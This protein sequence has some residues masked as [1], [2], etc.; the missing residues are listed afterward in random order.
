[1]CRSS[2]K[3]NIALQFT[4]AVFVV[5]SRLSCD[6]DQCA[7]SIG[8]MGGAGNKSWLGDI[9][10]GPGIMSIRFRQGAS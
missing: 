2:G 1:M 6:I 10:P 3:S 8:V 9:A 4:C 7:K 5:R